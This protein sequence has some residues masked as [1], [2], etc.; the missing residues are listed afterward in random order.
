[1]PLTVLPLITATLINLTP[2]VLNVVDQDG[3]LVT[4]PPSGTV[5][6]VSTSSTAVFVVNNI[7]VSRSVRGEV[8]D[9]P[10]P[11]DGVFFLVSMAVRDAVPDRQDVLS[12]GDL[13]RG[14][15][16]QPTGCNGLKVN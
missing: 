2:H 7:L 8:Q 10:D 12:P 1:M 15:D 13:L 14:P 5:A 11:Q 9:L 3:T 16:G 6:R 4:V